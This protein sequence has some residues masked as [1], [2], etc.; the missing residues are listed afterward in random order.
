MQGVLEQ[1]CQERGC[2][3][4]SSVFGRQHKVVL[5]GDLSN[6]QGYVGIG[7][8]RHLPLFP[9]TASWCVPRTR[10]VSNRNGMMCP[11]AS[12]CSSQVTT[13]SMISELSEL[14]VDVNLIL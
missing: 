14:L 12:F 11:C 8:C 4:P 10:T 9:C 6:D 13:L 7:I 1:W 2:R 3:W 5:S